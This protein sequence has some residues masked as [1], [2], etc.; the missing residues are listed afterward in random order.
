L[1]AEASKLKTRRAEILN[2][3]F[4]L[5]KVKE[6]KTKIDLSYNDPEWYNPEE[7]EK[8]HLILNKRRK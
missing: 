2:K 1:D 3:Y 6:S 4:N 7:C 5:P 8:I